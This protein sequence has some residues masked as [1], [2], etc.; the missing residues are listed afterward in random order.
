MSRAG[1]FSSPC[2][3]FLM[4]A[5][6]ILPSGSSLLAQEKALPRYK[7]HSRLLVYQDEEGKEREVLSPEDWE[8]RRRNILSGMEEA[9]GKLPDRSQLA[10]LDI[11][12]LERIEGDVYSRLKISFVP[13]KGDRVTAYLYLP[14]SRPPERRFPAMLALHPTSPL[15]KGVVAGLS[16]RPNRGYA[17]ELARRGYIVLAPDYPSFGDYP[18]D[19][20]ADRYVSGTMKGIF[21]HMRCV[22]LL[23]ARDD[24]DPER[25]GVIGHSLGGHNAMFLG[26][27]DRR[28][29]VIVSSC[30]WTPFHDYY[31]GKIAG[32]T[33]ARYMPRL[34]DTYG[35]DPDRVPFD[36]YEV[37]G[38]LAPR[39]FFSCSPEGDDNFAVAGVRKAIPEAQKVYRLLE[40]EELLQVRHPHCGHD[41][42]SPVRF[43]AYEFIDRV[44]KHT[45]LDAGNIPQDPAES[46]GGEIRGGIAVVEI[47]P[48][49]SYRM[50]GYFHE[51]LS[52]GT[53]D[54]L[55]AKALYLGQG[56]EQAALVFCDIIGISLDVSNRARRQASERTGIPA[57]RILVAATHSHTGPLYFGALRK[58]FHEQAVSSHGKDPHEVIDYPSL[59]VSQLVDVIAR[60][61]ALALPV[62]LEVGV[63]R[64]TRLSFNRRFHMK[65]GTVR[66]NPGKL[67]PNILRVAGPIDPDVGVLL[68]REGKNRYPLASL[69]NF[70]LHLDTVGGTQY[71]AD[72][73][74]Y[75]SRSL[76][77]KFGKNFVSL[78]S[79][80][81]CGDLNHIDVT[82]DRPQKGQEEAKRLGTSLAE[83][84]KKALAGGR[85]VIPRFGARS[86]T[87]QVP[88]QRYD[89]EKVARARRDL[90]KVGTGELPFLKQVEAY[91]IAALELREGPT[92]PMEVQVFRIGSDV[93][94]V[95]LPGEV[96]V[97]LALAIKKDSPF[98]TTVVLELCNDAPGYVPTRKAFAEG[99]YET[100]NSRIESGGGEMLVE[101]AARLL[102]ELASE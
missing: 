46:A 80:G 7:D 13:E 25:I 15:G 75:L 99:S 2:R 84:V 47:T 101:A 65:D 88:L 14:K 52:T 58:H 86:E 100:V 102:R 73:P 39:A 77:Q 35:L 17:L 57:S 67:N 66:F 38:A 19:F 53:H 11:S 48:P 5:A 30:G 20:D 21:N 59:L 70:A 54:P 69:V 41:F 22:D 63:A 45:P 18:Y 50:S 51:R 91:K 12:E 68:L 89:R 81:A 1:N 8:I 76:Q 90:F 93:A 36:F 23:A 27:F 92:L 83:S 44:L 16:T 62:V 98:K 96:F 10:L 49:P 64:E 33:S 71:S 78:F 55:L 85:P 29:K 87:V 79:I 40:A 6:L 61:Q 94:L 74:Y 3:V 72:Y 26:V 60:A 31:G 42:P 43:E 34:R 24:V 56:S 28:L 9:M 4:M 37:V 97:D 95:G 82:H 32:W